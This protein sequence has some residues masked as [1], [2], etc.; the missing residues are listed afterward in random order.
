M[1]VEIHHKLGSGRGSRIA[2]SKAGREAD[3]DP[4]RVKIGRYARRDEPTAVGISNNKIA[5]L[6]GARSTRD[7]RGRVVQL[8]PGG[9]GID[10]ERFEPDQQAGSALDDDRGS[11]VGDLDRGDVAAGVLR[12]SGGR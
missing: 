3:H 6:G 4:P 7:R 9:R 2:V 10:R 8:D 1:P 11:V 5:R 12:P